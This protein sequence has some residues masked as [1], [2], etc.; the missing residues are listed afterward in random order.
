VLATGAP[1][2]EGMA[3]PTVVTLP[4][5]LDR[6]PDTNHSPSLG[7]AAF[8]LDGH[9]WPA[10]DGCRL[11]VVADGKAHPLG[12]TVA[13]QR[14]TYQSTA[15]AEG[16]PV[17][18]RETL[19]LSHFATGGKLPRQL[20]FLDGDGDP[21]NVSVDWT[22][23]RPEELPSGGIVR[24]FFVARDLRGGLDWQTRSLCLTTQP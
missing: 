2:C 17:A 24:F 1:S 9:P 4:V 16:L 3:T 12:L 21:S 8:T 22:A 11:T 18:R 15:N 20:S 19:Q 23:P 6:G 14:E 5:L 7:A 13:G 10:G